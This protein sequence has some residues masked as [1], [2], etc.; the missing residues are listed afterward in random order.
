VISA[1]HTDAV[2]TDQ[3]NMRLSL[4]RANAVRDYL[5]AGGISAS[6]IRAEGFGESQPVASN[7]TAEG[8]AQ[9][10]RVELRVVGQ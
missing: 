9:N 2:G 8:R 3:Y 1:G 7:E 5:I 4:R 10:R 6:R